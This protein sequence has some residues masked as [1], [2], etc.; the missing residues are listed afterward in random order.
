M[1]VKKRPYRSPARAEQARQTRLR[2]LDAAS[3]LFVERGFAATSIG[4][5]AAEADVTS[6]TV[7]L[8]FANKRALLDMAIGV[9]LGGDDAPVMVR[10]RDWFL[11]TIEAP[12]GETL[13]LFAKFITSLHVRSAAL[14]EAAEA[15]AAADPE[16]ADG[17]DE[18]HR[19]RHDDMRRIASA[20]A[21]KTDVDVEYVTDLLFSLGSSAVYVLFVFQCG[22]SPD[23]YERWLREALEAAVLKCLP[24]LPLPPTQ[25]SYRSSSRR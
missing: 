8:A 17:R 18:G 9:A 3:R 21:T 22:W 19:R 23:R 1:D 4:D 7:H 15:A 5:I 16:L 2:I 25:R 20:I 11:K 12:V 24:L 6:R 13:A 10:D 14:L